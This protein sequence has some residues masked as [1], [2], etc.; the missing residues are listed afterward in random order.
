MDS[1]AFKLKA[2]NAI[3]QARNT[4]LNTTTESGSPAIGAYVRLYLYGACAVLF[5]LGF[6]A[7]FTASFIQGT[8]VMIIALL[9]AASESTFLVP[10]V[11]K[12]LTFYLE[13]Y[14]WRIIAYAILTLPTFFSW[15]TFL[16]GL[17][18]LIGCAGYGYCVFKGEKPVLISASS[19]D[20]Q[21]DLTQEFESSAFDDKGDGLLSNYQNV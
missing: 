15:T 1:V 11:E 21:V 10:P 9:I 14:L 16:G 3:R 19:K 6:I 13:N 4:L 17:L 2:A 18:I 20:A 5:F 8:I 12:A 7:W